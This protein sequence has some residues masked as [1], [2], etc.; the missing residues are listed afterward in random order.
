MV[1]GGEHIQPAEWK[2]VSNIIQKV[3][4]WFIH[5]FRLNVIFGFLMAGHG[6]H[7]SDGFALRLFLS[8]FVQI[9]GFKID[10]KNAETCRKHWTVSNFASK[11]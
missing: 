9:C 3:S 4:N 2:T 1:D 7:F 6:A 8:Y 11:I 10:Y 5:E